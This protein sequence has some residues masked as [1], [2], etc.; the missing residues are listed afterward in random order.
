[1]Q[2]TSTKKRKKGNSEREIEIQ[3]KKVD[4]IIPSAP[5]RRVV[6]EL[7]NKITLSNHIRYQQEAVTALQTATES[8]MVDL[9]QDANLLALYSGRE[10]LHSGDIKVAL[11]LK[12]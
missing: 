12:K 10:T 3:Q 4:L 5:F 8:F 6:D 2:R 7:T 11:R 1:M 9:F